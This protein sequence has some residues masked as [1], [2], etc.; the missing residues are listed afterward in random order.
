MA[1][2]RLIASEHWDIIQSFIG[3][4]YRKPDLVI[5]PN[6]T[7]Y[8]YRWHLLPRNDLANAYLHLQ[9]ADDPERPL[10][11][12]PY[13]NQSVILAGGYQEVMQERPFLVP[14][15]EQRRK[16]QTVWRKAEIAHRLVL[17]AA[18]PYT[19][20]LFTTGPVRRDWGFWIGQTWYSHTDCISHD[21]NGKSVF[22]YPKGV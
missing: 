16:G 20:T 1:E 4:I 11:D 22:H 10:H 18:E 12:H 14:T 3:D 9:V 7:P 15:L 19:M 17:P 2:D 21:R 13:D 6:G 8:L 5:A